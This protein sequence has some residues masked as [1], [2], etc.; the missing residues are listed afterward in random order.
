MLSRT[1]L[2][3]G[4]DRSYLLA[5]PPTLAAGT[6]LPL[7]VAFHGGGI[8]AR[9][10]SRLSN[11]HELAARGLCLVAYPDGTGRVDRART[12]NAGDCCGHAHRY[13][14][15]DVGFV[16]RLCTAIEAEWPVDPRRIYATGFSN[17]GMLC[18]HL[19]SQLPDRLAAI[20][21]VAAAMTCTLSS[22]TQAV[23]VLA[24]HGTCD[25]YVPIAGGRGPKSRAGVDYRP[26]RETLDLWAARNGCHFQPHSTWLTVPQHLSA[27][28]SPP[29]IRAT[30]GALPIED[31]DYGPGRGASEVRAY[32]VHGGGHTW[33]GQPSE[34]FELG[35]TATNLSANEAIWE[36]FSRHRRI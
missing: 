7:I 23:P 13:Q 27:T 10:M 12:W 16:D 9:A 11:I 6:P 1:F 36:F 18:Y 5:I 21:P 2:H 20:A 33:P 29:D 24:I 17:G 15:D 32:I 14:V 4:R 8:N 30:H 3:Q 19:A 35:A 26:L 25:Q 22:H 34:E 31:W 28:T